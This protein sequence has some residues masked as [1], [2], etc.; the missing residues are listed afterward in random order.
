MH[1][2]RGLLPD[3]VLT[4]PRYPADLGILDDDDDLG[5]LDDTMEAGAA[6]GGSGGDVSIDLSDAIIDDMVR[7]LV[8]LSLGFAF[9][10]DSPVDPPFPRCAMP[11]H[12]PCLPPPS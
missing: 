11:P 8:S 10:W 1:G 3:R 9:V 2:L 4:F 12:P 5:I 7:T 6:T